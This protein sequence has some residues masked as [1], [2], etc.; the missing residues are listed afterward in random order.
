MAD[1]SKDLAK[2]ASAQLKKLAESHE[3]LAADH[4]AAL[5]K[6]A[7]L[8]KERECVNLAIEMAENGQF[9]AT[10]ESIN[11]VAHDLMSQDLD[12]VKKAMTLAADG[13]RIGS[14]AGDSPSVSGGDPI[15]EL[16]L[17]G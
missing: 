8:E 11:K 7:T 4:A 5:D 13:L 14:P 9:T 17:N 10:V 6:L 2:Q 1:L 12:V 16:L 3:K 15:T